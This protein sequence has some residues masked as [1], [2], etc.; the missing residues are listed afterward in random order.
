[1]NPRKFLIIL[2]SVLVCGLDMTAQKTR[3][4]VGTTN[5]QVIESVA[6]CEL[7]EQQGI[8]RLIKRFNAGKRPGYLVLHGDNLY[9]VSTDNQAEEEQTIRAFHR[10]NIENSLEM[11]DEVSSRGINPCHIAV[12]RD[13]SS[14]FTANYTSGSIAQYSIMNDGS[15]GEN[16][17]FEQLIGSGVNPERQEGPHAHYINSTH[18]GRFVLTAD[19]GTDKVMIHKIDDQGGMSVYE[20]QPFFELPPGSG[21]RHLEFHPNNQWI[22]VLNELNSTISSVLYQ[23]NK[24]QLVETI[25]TLPE[26]F[27]GTS[28]PAAVRLHPNGRYV[29]SSNRGSDSISVYEIDAE[30][31]LVRVQTFGEKLGWV[32]DFNVTP[33]GNF[34]VAG[35]ERTNRVVLL[36][37]ASDGRIDKYLSSLELPNPSCFVFEASQ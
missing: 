8:I 1:M 9:T 6:L 14:V 7:D 29:Y 5:A 13:G 2:I 15:F 22:Y 3:I 17:Y 32:R 35:N 21:P 10:N 26:D 19:L 28:Y 16:L 37:L 36:R 27:E 34:L 33:S 12:A 30:G 20:T 24:F 25:S 18:D 11:I 4:L 23:N 31:K